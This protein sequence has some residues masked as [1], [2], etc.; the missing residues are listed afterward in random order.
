MVNGERLIYN[1]VMLQCD[2]ATMLKTIGHC[3]IIAFQHYRIVTQIYV[4]IWWNF[5]EVINRCWEG[6]TSLFL[7]LCDLVIEIA[8]FFFTL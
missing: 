6:F 1:A 4:E 7:T 2:N 8:Q 3:S 5:L